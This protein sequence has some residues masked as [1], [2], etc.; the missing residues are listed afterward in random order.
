MALRHFRL[1]SLFVFGLVLLVVLA[2]CGP[3]GEPQIQLGT[4]Q[5]ELGTLTNGQVE[6]FEVAVHNSGSAP[7]MIEAVTTSC[8]CTS[9]SVSPETIQPGESGILAVTYDS[10]AH[11]PEFSGQVVR[12]V[13][14]ASNDPET[15]EVVLDLSAD[16]VLEDG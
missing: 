9:A 6:E 7:L 14:V 4:Y 11:G 10:G 8:G 5:I 13:F 15:R 1:Y 3:G 16:V 2:A 12:Q